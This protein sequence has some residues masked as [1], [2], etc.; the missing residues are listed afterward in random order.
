[1]ATYTIKVQNESGF[2]KD[3][4]VFQKPPEVISNGSNV[5]VFSNAWITFTG[6]LP[7]SFN[8]LTYEDITYA[9]WGTMTSDMSSTTSITQG[10]STLVNTAT[11]DG[12]AFQ[13]DDY[14]GFGDVTTGA[15]SNTGS[16]QISSSSDFTAK[17]H[18]VFGMSKPTNTAIPAPVATFLAQPN[19]NFDIIP[20][21]K[22]YV[23]DGSYEA[24]E[25]INVKQFSAI[26]AEIDFTGRSQTTATVV[27]QD[28]GVFTVEYS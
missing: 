25:I 2:G 14:T 17:D 7:G 16:Y 1:M 10:G 9:Y 12:V 20:V 19:D 27:Q 24:G 22:F 28:N 11:Q 5:E 3:Y 21:V 23:A 13:A 6:I 18:F 8:S 4:V 26:P 15:S